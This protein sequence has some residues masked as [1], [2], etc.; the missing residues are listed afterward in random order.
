MRVLLITDNA[1]NKGGAEA[2]FFTLKKYLEEIPDLEVFS[3]M[4]GPKKVSTDDINEI[5]LDR[6]KNNTIILPAVTSNFFKLLWRTIFHPFMYFRLRKIFK[7]IRPDVIHLHNIKQYTV[8]LLSALHAYPVVQTVHDFSYICPTAQNIHKNNEPC[9]TGLNLNC[10][11]QHRSKFNFF[12]YLALLPSFYVTRFLAKRFIYEFISPSPLLQSY[13]QKN[14]KNVNY[15]F[16]FKIEMQ[17]ISFEDI[18]PK[19]FLFAGNLGTHKGVLF[20]IEEF[21]LALQT[22]PTLIL[23]IVGEG[24]LAPKLKQKVK[25]LKLEENIFF[26][27]WQTDLQHLYQQSIAVIFPSTGLESFGL[28]LIEAMAYARP[29]IAGNRGTVKW[30]VDDKQTGLLFEPLQKGELAKLILLISNNIPLAQE[31]GKNASEK[32][33]MFPSNQATIHTLVRIYQRLAENK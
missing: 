27:K 14:F 29:V 22:Q 6:K 19:Q 32:L 8:S 28:I 11:W 16:P 21:A 30:L 9:P 18:N 10:L 13:L 5:K 23:K 25:E 20:L 26:L 7:T 24:P 12:I 4:F 15:V 17:N 2:Y 3:L 1:V 31:L 33:K